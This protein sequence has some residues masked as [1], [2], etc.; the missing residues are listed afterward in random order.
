MLYTW[1]EDRKRRSRFDVLIA[2][3][4]RNRSHPSAAAHIVP[5]TY[6]THTHIVPYVYYTHICTTHT[7]TQS[8]LY[9]LHTLSQKLYSICN[10][11][12]YTTHSHTHTL[13]PHDPPRN[14]EFSAFCWSHTHA[15]THTHTLT[16]THTHTHT[17]PNIIH[18]PVVNNGKMNKI[19]LPKPGAD[20]FEHF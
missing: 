12:T 6:Y 14:R 10:T 5:Y 1:Y 20:T 18:S 17:C 2:D 16:H 4:N 9:A 19:H 13:F 3:C 8:T 15:H 11:H 7:H